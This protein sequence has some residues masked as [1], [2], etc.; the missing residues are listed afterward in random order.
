MRSRSKLLLAGAM[1]VLAL[2][3][4]VS[5]ASANR[6][7]INERGVRITWA[8]LSFIAGTNTVSCPVTLEG[9]FHSGTIRKVARALIGYIS[10]AIVNGTE[11]PCTGGTATVLSETLPWHIQYRAFTGALPRI[12][13]VS[14]RLIGASFRVRPAGLVACLARTT[15]AEPA[16]GEALVNEATGAVTGLRA[17][18]E[19]SIGLDGFLCAFAGEGHFGGIGQ[20]F[21]LGT[22]RQDIF[23]TLI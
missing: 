7:S 12:R 14:L 9:S 22:T 19:A 2:S 5:T 23:I 4:G 1:A 6:L 21:R 18:E 8:R 3:M 17:N 20:V 13:T 10:R 11:G 16:Q 15:E